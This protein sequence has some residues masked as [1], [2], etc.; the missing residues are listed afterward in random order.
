MKFIK[1]KIF[2]A[3]VFCLLLLTAHFASAAEL[4]LT[5][6]NQELATGQQ[7]QVDLK[8]NTE[9][10][11]V[12][13]IE[14]KIIF[15]KDLLELEEIRDGNSVIN[16]WIEEPKLEQAGMI[17]FSG[18]VPGGF[19][20]TKGFLFSAVF[21]TKSSGSGVIQI[22][23]A[24][25]L[26]NDGKGTEAKTTISNFQFSISEK[27]QAGQPVVQPVKDTSPPEVFNPEISSNSE[28]FNGKWFLV[29]ATQDK[30]SGIDYYQ[31]MES[32]QFGSFKS[33][34]SKNSWTLAN[35]PYLLQDQTLRSNILVKAVDK[36]G[37]QRIMKI[38]P[39]NSL[40]LY[41]NYLV[42]IIIILGIIVY[43]I[44]KIKK[45]KD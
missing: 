25:V 6:Q 40:Q 12:N 20:E 45:R 8:V 4:N 21:R 9:N 42:W 15:S 7:F 3:L 17:G 10:E 2:V 22:S 44:W 5:A 29:F 16:F 26:L 14:G 37:N 13:A 24:K 36:A 23:D 32:A 43:I 31:I 35:S 28:I 34:F 19:R 33:L 18:I 27:I 41:E 38:N 30:G 1:N 39:K 11:D